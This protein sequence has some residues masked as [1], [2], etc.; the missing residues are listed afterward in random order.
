M[1]ELFVVII[2]QDEQSGDYLAMIKSVEDG[3][4]NVVRRPKLAQVLKAAVQRMSKRALHN[5]KFPP[6]PPSPIIRP[7]GNGD[8]RLIVPAHN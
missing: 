3:K 7:N 6:P 1:K 5:R 2:S 8:V 4:G